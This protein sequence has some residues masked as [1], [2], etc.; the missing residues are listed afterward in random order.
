VTPRGFVV[1]EMIP[2]L[3]WDELAARTAAP[4]LSD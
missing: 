1:R 4:L 3:S 2:G